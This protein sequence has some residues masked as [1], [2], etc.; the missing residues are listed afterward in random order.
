MGMIRGFVKSIH[1]QL[2]HTHNNEESDRIFEGQQY[3]PSLLNAINFHL[4]A[5]Y[6]ALFI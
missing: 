1:R 5:G 4:A 2:G 6:K 3:K